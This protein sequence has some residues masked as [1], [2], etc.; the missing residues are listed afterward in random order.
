MLATVVDQLT[1]LDD[2]ALTDHFRNLE[3]THRRLDAEMAAIIAE[4]ERRNIAAVDGHHSMKGWLRANANWS[5]AHV[6][7][8][9]K[10]AKTVTALPAI[11]D[12]LAAGRI[13]V[14]QADEL[15]RVATNR[16]VADQ[17][18]D[19]INILLIQAEQ[20]SFE[21][22]RTCLRRW[23]ALADLDGAH[24]DREMSHERRTA[25]V[26]EI[27]GALYARATGGTAEVAAEL[28]AIFKQALESEFRVDVAERTRLHGPDTPAS[29][30]PRPD[31]Q[32]RF[33]AMTSIFRRCVAVPADAKT[34]APLVNMMSVTVQELLE[35]VSQSKLAGL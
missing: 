15:A 26:T 34:P 31:A 12:A 13:G 9:R 21:D 19:S 32:R 11:G 2:N 17:L 1:E 24:R 8:S 10:L 16:R 25:T 7:R 22:A 3:L 29:L 35:H 6:S 18:P 4:G 27:D 14:D 5:N 33:D 20:L 23:Q 28:E 30:L